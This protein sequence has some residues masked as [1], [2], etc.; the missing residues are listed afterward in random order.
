MSRL[1]EWALSRAG[2]FERI[3]QNEAIALAHLKADA[4]TPAVISIHVAQRE[5]AN[6]DWL[7]TS[8]GANLSAGFHPIVFLRHTCSQLVLA[9]WRN[10]CRARPRNDVADETFTPEQADLIRS[11]LAA[12][13]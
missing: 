1:N 10:S 12:S 7:A 8:G 6:P 2:T 3:R 5:I 9:A 13:R 11:E 4:P